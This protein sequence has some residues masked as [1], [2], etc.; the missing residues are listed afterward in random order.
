MAEWHTGNCQMAR[1]AAEWWDGR[2]AKM[3][4]WKMEWRNGGQMAGW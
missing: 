2:M 3:A 4:E 1:M